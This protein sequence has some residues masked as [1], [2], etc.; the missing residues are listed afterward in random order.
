MSTSSATT[1]FRAIEVH[2]AAKSAW[3]SQTED[4]RNSA[5]DPLFDELNDAEQELVNAPTST[6]AEV[7]QKLRYLFAAA[8]NDRGK[9]VEDFDSVLAALDFHFADS[10]SDSAT[11]SA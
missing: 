1:L 8:T 7:V 5:V 2:Q 11:A 4:A 9:V 6:D 10:N 3:H